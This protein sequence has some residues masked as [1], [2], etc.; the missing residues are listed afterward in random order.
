MSLFYAKK[1]SI[2]KALLQLYLVPFILLLLMGVVYLAKLPREPTHSDVLI[3]SGISSN[4]ALLLE[5]L[6]NNN[7]SSG[8][9]PSL[10]AFRYPVDC[11]DLFDPHGQNAYF[12]LA[13]SNLSVGLGVCISG[14]KAVSKNEFFLA[15]MPLDLRGNLSYPESFEPAVASLPLKR[16]DY[17]E[18]FSYKLV[19]A[20]LFNANAPKY[21]RLPVWFFTIKD[22][23]SGIASDYIISASG[24]SV[25]FNGTLPS[26]MVPVYR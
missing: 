22:V 10:V 24:N 7:I 2:K 13:D 9:W 16:T 18:S 14:S 4:P 17:L 1:A 6:A 12:V 23:R 21:A 19:P 20:S 11:P 8:D 15:D 25:L 26:D 3:R 5:Y